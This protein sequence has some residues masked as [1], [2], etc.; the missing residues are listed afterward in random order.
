[1]NSRSVSVGQTVSAGQQI[2][3]LGSTGIST[4][5]HLHFEV[6]VN[7]SAVNPMNYF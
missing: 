6:F 1:M 2:G 7:G 5:P 4:G 3:K